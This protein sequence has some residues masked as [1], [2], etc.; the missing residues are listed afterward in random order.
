MSAP[1]PPA[2]DIDAL[3]AQAQ[4]GDAEAAFRLGVALAAERQWPEALHWQ[5]RAAAAGHPGAALECG[6]MQLYGI[7]G[8]VAPAEALRALHQAEQAGLPA[9]SDLLVQI[10]LGGVALPR[11]GRI[12]QRLMQAVQ[13]GHP[14]ALL[15]AALHFGRKP[16]PEDQ[17]LCLQ[18]LE[19]GAAR[20]DG[21]CAALLAERLAHGEGCAVQAQTAGEIRAQLDA[22]GVPRLPAFTLPPPDAPGAPPRQ[23]ALEDTLRAPTPRL[24]SEAPRVGVVDALL[25]ADE[26][27]LMILS[28]A[29]WLRDSRVADPRTGDSL[30][31]SLRT[32]SETQIDPVLDTTALRLIQLRMA[33]AAGI[34]LPNAEPT[35]VL[36]YLP[37][38][39]YRPHRDYLPLGA[40]QRD[41][42]LA[43]NRAR[44]VCAYLAPVAAGGA[45]EFPLAGVRVDPLPGRVVI[46]DNLKPD[47]SPDPDSLHAG[48][49]VESGEK[50]LATLWI[51]ERRYRDW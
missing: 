6:R 2:P 4:A 22:N 50:W 45:T 14:P 27:R 17:T 25:S 35:T 28:A 38:Q 16:H 23:L 51:R 34:D 32:S 3:R 24:L 42:G 47:G 49:P 48:L 12:N 13:A 19:R 36:H 43:G 30:A 33:A 41:R 26:C 29:P 31:Q 18:L 20:G 7:G 8:P 46:F 15:A 37:G 9:A 1:S 5:Q 40:L 44:T 10:A 11:D 39:E 21:A